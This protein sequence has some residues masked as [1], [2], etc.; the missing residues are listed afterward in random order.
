MLTELQQYLLGL[1]KPKNPITH[2]VHDQPY[3]VCVDGTLGAAVLD[4]PPLESALFSVETLAG[5]VDAFRADIDK[6]SG[7]RPG[8]HV[9]NH[10]TVSLVALDGD[11]FGRRH[12]W[13]RATCQ[14]AQPFVFGE[15]Q[16][17]EKFLITLQQGFLPTEEV[18]SLQRLASSLTTENSVSTSDDG[19][20]Q[21]VTV[22]GGSVSR[23]L[24]T[25]PT[26]IPLAPYRSFREL[27]PCITNF[28]VRMKGEPGKLPSIALIELDAGKWRLD[29][30]QS[31]VQWLRAELT[32]AVILS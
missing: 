7:L 32:D 18:V 2:E 6:F 12:E 17:P 10:R 31:I 4:V 11:R 25:L 30:I 26:R 13:L 21:K 15:Y 27:T 1:L 8:I 9:L 23:S 28:M 22:S 19:M 20:S 3:K 29:T 14:E 16:A 24:V 5:F